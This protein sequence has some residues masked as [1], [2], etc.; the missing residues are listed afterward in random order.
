M[1]LMSECPQF[2]FNATKVSSP[3]KVFQIMEIK[4]RKGL[5]SCVEC[6]F[7]SRVAVA[8][9]IITSGKLITFDGHIVTAN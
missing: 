8:T 1:E 4:S 6:V 3:I 5:F 9:S 2:S 7:F